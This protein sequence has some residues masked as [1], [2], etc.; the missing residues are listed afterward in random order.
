MPS[1]IEPL[2]KALRTLQRAT[3][4]EPGTTDGVIATVYQLIDRGRSAEY[5]EIAAAAAGELQG[6]AVRIS[7][8]GPCYAFAQMQASPVP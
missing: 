1:E 5:G 3:R 6:L 7:G 4:V 8:P 2:L